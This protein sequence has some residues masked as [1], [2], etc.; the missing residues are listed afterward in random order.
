MQSI[1]EYGQSA[2]LLGAI[3]RLSSDVA[4]KARVRVVQLDE[5]ESLRRSATASEDE[6]GSNWFW[7]EV[8][9]DRVVA[10]S[11][12]LEA[13]AKALK[14][15]SERPTWRVLLGLDRSYR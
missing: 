10:V 14:K 9:S 1:W 7:T 8:R 6:P 11:E 12:D 3:G 4:H 15:L 13:L 2:D 5:L